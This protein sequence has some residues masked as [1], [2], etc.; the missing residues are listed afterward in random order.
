MGHLKKFLDIKQSSAN[1]KSLVLYLLLAYLFSVAIRLFLYYQFSEHDHYF[2]QGNIIP[3]WTHD[4]GLYGFYTNQLLNGISYPFISEYTPAY[5][6]YGV[7]TITGLELDTVLFFAPAFFSS[8][9]IIPIILIANHY[10]I[11]RMGLYSALIGSVMT[12][13]YYRTHL[14]YYDTDIL[15]AMLPL[16]SIFFLIRL[17]QSHKITHALL[18]SFTLV[19]FALWYHSS[20]PI[21]LSIVMIFLLYTLLF[22]R[23]SI[24]AYQSLLILSVALLPLAFFYNIILLMLLPILFTMINKFDNIDYRH[25]L[26]IFMIAI[27]TFFLLANTS[28]YYD[29]VGNYLNKNNSITITSSQGTLQL[30][31]DLDSVSEAKNLNFNQLANRISGTLPF[32]IIALLGY[33]ALLI[34]YRS[35]I[36]T[37][38]LI[39]IALI[40]VVAGTRFTLYGVMPFAFALVFGVYL[41]FRIILVNGGGFSSKISDGISKLFLVLV[42]IF[43]LL[44]I[45]NHNQ[46]LSPI[47]FSST[48]DIEALKSLKEDSKKEDFILSWWDY[49]WPLWYYTEL[50]TLI[51]N[52]KHQ[53]DNFIVSKILLSNSETFVKNASTFFINQYREGQSKGIP[54][55]MDYFIQNHPIEYLKE[56]EKKSFIPKKSNRDIYILLHNHMFSTLEV[57]ESFSNLNLKS[58]KPHRSNMLS[59]GYLNQRYQPSGN[60]LQTATFTIDIKKGTIASSAGSL[61]I[62]KISIVNNQKIKLEKSYISSNGSYIVINNGEVLM[63]K[64]KLYN[65]FLIQALLFNNYNRDYFTKVEQTKNFLILKVNNHQTNN[66]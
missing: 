48:Q 53:Q 16:L 8:L 36:L 32:F 26:S 45:L 28:K 58:G 20:A 62:R 18:A 63:L 30:K 19:I 46:K 10:K 23:K 56:L 35:M 52:G 55:V 7:V 49:S 61:K 9:I 1:H 51:D 38:P 2:F 43:A 17:T 42:L 4:S 6:L 37:L 25:Y 27:I 3:T 50:N 31:S 54:K 60:I 41:L 13:Y 5:L 21:I 57:I 66:P 12:S 11:V 15:N 33:I 65:S 64:P 14:G 34:K 22:E 39:A 29:R 47:L 24:Y 44:N 40:S 59:L